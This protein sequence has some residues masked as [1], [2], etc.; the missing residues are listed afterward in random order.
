MPPLETFSPELLYMTRTKND[1]TLEYLIIA[2]Y[3]IIIWGENL[4]FLSML[5]K[6]MWTDWAL[7]KNETV[8]DSGS[9]ISVN[10]WYHDS[11]VTK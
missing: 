5:M 4:K 11:M 9:F 7:E 2:G 3:G 6:N 1:A 8:L 10:C